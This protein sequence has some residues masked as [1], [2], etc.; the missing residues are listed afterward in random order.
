MREERSFATK[1][2]R[3]GY[4]IALFPVFLQTDLLSLRFFII[5]V[6]HIPMPGRQRLE[7]KCDE[8]GGKLPKELLSVIYSW[9]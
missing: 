6:Q 5:R 3:I 4:N 9:I 2:A 1:R 7:W 8:N